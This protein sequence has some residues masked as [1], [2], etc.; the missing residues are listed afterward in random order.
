MALVNIESCLNSSVNFSVS[1][2][3]YSTTLGLV[4][5]ITGDTNIPDG[6]YTIGSLVSSTVTIDGVATLVTDCNDSLCS[7]Y[8]QNNYCLSIPIS[9]YSGYN[10][11][12]TL[13]GNYGGDYYW[14]GG[15]TPGYIFFNGTNW[16]L[17]NSLGGTCD[18]FG[19]NPTTYACP[20]LDS[21]IMYEGTCSI[22][23][24]PT[25]PCS[26]LDFDV[27]LECDIPTP[28]PTPGPNMCFVI[29]SE[30]IGTNIL[31]APININKVLHNLPFEIYKL[32]DKGHFF[33]SI[34]FINCVIYKDNSV[35]IKLKIIRKIV[36]H[37]NIFN[38]IF[39]VLLFI[40]I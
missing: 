7:G 9:S 28:T 2:W 3:S 1:G 40:N 13:E 6:C 21:T 23:P 19:Q 35:N 33:S 32:F 36:H 26:D 37:S 12:Y 8:C 34:A 18:F 15:T 16:C 10:G 31:I 38:Y 11:T 20:D 29:D 25:D 4:F 14:T 30:L 27:L 39:Y 24:I 5:N 22:T 17:S